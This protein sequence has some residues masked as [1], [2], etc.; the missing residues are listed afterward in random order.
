MFFIT[1]IVYK[2][3]HLWIMGSIFLVKDVEPMWIF[4]IAALQILVGSTL[5]YLTNRHQRGL[6]QPLAQVVRWP[7]MLLLLSALPLLASQYPWSTSLFSWLLLLMS[8]LYLIP[9]LMLWWRPRR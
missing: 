5:L 7:A 3:L 4:A 1:I 8:A 2:E 9:T 6:A